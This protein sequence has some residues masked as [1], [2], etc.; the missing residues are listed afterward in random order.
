MTPVAPNPELVIGVS[1]LGLPDPRPVAEVRRAGG[2]G[3]LD[4]G[5]GDR[6]AREA[7]A[8]VRRWTAGAFA[9][10]VGPSCALTPEEVAE[11]CGG[12]LPPVVL[13]AADADW[14]I[15]QLADECRVLAEVGDQDEAR[16]AAADGAYGLVARGSECGGR[17]GELST[18]VLLQALLADPAYDLPVW[19]CGGIGPR[20]AAA[21]VV[22]GAAGVVLDTQLA[23]LAES[24][25]DDA[26]AAVLR[27]ADGSGT[28]IVDG[29][30]ALRNARTG[31]ELPVGQ[32][33]FLAARF[34]DRWGTVASAVRGVREAILAAVGDPGVART[35]AAGSAMA[36][37]LG[38]RLP[39][40]QGPMTR[41][42]DRAGF[43]AAV[44]REGALPMLA[45]ALS[46][47]EQSRA[48]LERT[49]DDLGE[50]PWGVGI[51]GFADS[52]I[53]AEQLAAVR[54]VRPTH[55][56]IAGA[57]PPRRPT[58]RRS[59]SRRSC[60]CRRPRCSN[61]SLTWACANLSSKAP[62]AADTSD[63][64][65]AFRSGRRSW[66]WSRST[67]PARPAP[68]A[69]SR[70]CSRAAS[71]TSAPRPW[72]RPSPPRSPRA[73]SRSAS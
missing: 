40:V 20:T 28:S 29:V 39:V 41:V 24:G 65:T 12:D 43:A 42:S 56:I 53:R 25:T 6:R 59:A 52:R 68:R 51:L 18:F 3:V 71:T 45:L 50:R 48:L 38:T 31:L 10:R 4:L 46:D 69:T 22:G 36:D 14:K 5:A 11:E 70:C 49:R 13:L 44:A 66:R 27:T 54:A 67:W 7:L 60:T 61:S 23:L 63:R 9:V 47:G 21:A 34:A 1:P 58:W 57:A 2:L 32:D 62:N 17:G 19:A 64:A 15:G 33:A 72:P 35:L 37:A 73:G 16:R 30:R 55:A 8:R 26:A